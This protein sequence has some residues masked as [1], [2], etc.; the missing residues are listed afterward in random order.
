M[1]MDGGVGGT[2]DK[3][4]KGTKTQRQRR[5]RWRVNRCEDR[6]KDT[7]PAEVGRESLLYSWMALCTIQSIHPAPLLSPLSSSP[8]FSFPL[9]SSPVC[10]N[11]TL[12]KNYKTSYTSAFHII[13]THAR[14]QHMY[15]HVHTITEK[16]GLHVD[17]STCADLKHA[18]L[19]RKAEMSIHLTL[20][21][22]F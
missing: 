4:P 14:L 10:W 19:Y 11:L 13:F 21:I 22:F 17:L 6:G 16:R 12:S 2:R 1:W 5:E 20:W 18:P 9:S 15:L 8:F 3:N 7:G